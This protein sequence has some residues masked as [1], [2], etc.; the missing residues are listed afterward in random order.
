MK[1][2]K[3]KTNPFG[4]KSIELVD[5][6]ER[7][8][9]EC[10]DFEVLLEKKEHKIIALENNFLSRK[11]FGK[12]FKDSKY[13]IFNL[14]FGLKNASYTNNLS[15][16]DLVEEVIVLWDKRLNYSTF[17]VDIYQEISPEQLDEIIEFC[18]LQETTDCERETTS[19]DYQ[20]NEGD[21]TIRVICEDEKP[22]KIIIGPLFN[23]LLRG[24]RENLK[25]T[26]SEVAARIGVELQS[27][28]RYEYGERIP[29]GKT[30]IKLV[31]LLN[32]N[33]LDIE[34]ALL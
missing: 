29:D 30:M 19:I 25:L 12:L 17:T 6:P 3:V 18:D 22:V 23:E 9:V 13:M 2:I 4:N 7:V 34:K 27:Y 10:K 32:L 21:Y 8:T 11:Y 16:E 14:A 33:T 1:R 5:A 28:Q 15:N 20:G 26:Q 31:R 24:A